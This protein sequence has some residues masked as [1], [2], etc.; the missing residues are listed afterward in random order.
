[1][2]SFSVYGSSEAFGIVG[3]NHIYFKY[4]GSSSVVVA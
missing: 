3:T 4:S 1:M 2:K